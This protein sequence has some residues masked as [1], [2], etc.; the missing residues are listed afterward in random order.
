MELADAKSAMF[1]TNTRRCCWLSTPW[2]INSRKSIVKTVCSSSSLW[3]SRYSSDLFSLLSSVPYV[4]GPPGSASGSVSH[5]YGSGCGSESFPFLI[6]CWA[7]WNNGCKIKFYYKNFL[8]TNKILIIKHIFT[9]LKL[10]N[11]IIKHWKIWRKKTIFLHS[12]SH[13][14]F[15]YGSASASGSV[16]R[17]YGS[18]DRDP[19]QFVT[20]P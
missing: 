8:A 13:W 20:D 17:R 5:R 9:I 7:D 19:Y 2:R 3:N 12:K 14:R 1:R 6:K 15:W 16:S 11:F 10:L 18:E 4:F